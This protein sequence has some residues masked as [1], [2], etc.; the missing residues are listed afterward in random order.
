MK[1]VSNKFK[2][3]ITK[4]GREIDFRINLHINDR[5]I[6]QDNKFL[7]TEDNLKLIVEQFNENDIDYTINA[8][9]I[10]NA[11][12]VTNGNLLS[13]MM[14]EFD[15]EAKEELR[16]GD[17]VDCEFGLKVD[18]EYEYVNYGKYVLFSKEY[19]EDTKT[20]S[21]VCYDSM[22]LSMIEAD[23]ISIIQN[24]TVQTAIE[25]ICNKTGLSVNITAEDITNFPNLENLI[26]DG[27]FTNVEMTYRDV[28]DTICQCL[29][30]SMIVNDKTLI[31]KTFNNNIVDSFNE[32][33]LKDINVTFAEKYGP[34]N[35]VTLSRSEDSD[36]IYRKDEES[37]LSNGLH[38]FKIKDNLI[39]NLNDREDY[40]DEIFE[41]LNGLEFYVNDFTSTGITYLDWLDFYNINIGENSYKC[42]MLN[43]EINITQGLE[44]NIYTDSPEEA[45][46]NYKTSGKTDKEVSFIVD[47]QRGEISAKVSKGD[48]IN[49]IN[50]DESGA[51]INANK[52]SLAGK[53][54]EMT[55]DNI[56]INS[57]NFKVDKDGNITATSGI[58]GGTV[59]TNKNLTVGD[60]AY[61]GQ[62]QTSAYSSPRYIYLNEDAYI[63]RMLFTSGSYLSIYS[64]YN[65]RLD[66]QGTGFINVLKDGI[67]MSHQPSIISDKRLKQNIK[68]ID[69]SFIDELKV[70]EFEYIKTPNKKQIGLIAQDYENKDYA[71]YFLSKDEN[72][73]YSIAYGNITNALIQYCQEMKK[74]IKELK[75]E[76]K[77]LKGDD[78]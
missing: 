54:I 21:Y 46:S 70:K 34:V 22:L 56:A 1:I 30:V 40:I 25:N 42:L 75:K 45:V 12:V 43:D 2:E 76:I 3:E 71:K 16:I 6:T 20:Y 14:K 35:S 44:E 68:N 24:V 17:I 69:T 59:N 63:R 60:N 23:D 7:T 52:I 61:I 78:I 73:C 29:G 11:Q 8:N 5:I 26:N 67:S 58:F 31:F 57:T 77:S 33:Y 37:I 53:T 38:E 55:S 49:E 62:N 19:N 13:T 15:F 36:I 64:T 74:E 72:E 47:K 66:C 18:G 41:Q 4:L 9:D 50:L 27:T 39:L 48:V 32:K 65:T 10:Y 28:L 51:S